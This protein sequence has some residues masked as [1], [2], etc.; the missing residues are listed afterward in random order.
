MSRFLLSI[1]TNLLE[2]FNQENSH[3]SLSLGE[4]LDKTAAYAKSHWPTNKNVQLA[5]IIHDIGK[6]FTKT[7]Y[8]M[9]GEKTEEA[10]YY[11]HENYGTYIFLQDFICESDIINKVPTI[12]NKT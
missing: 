7:F 10:H 12:A 4:H 1:D 2:S 6:Y 5:A 3:H 8:N 11:G 9:K